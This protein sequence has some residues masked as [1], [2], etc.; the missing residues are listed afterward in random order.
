V[1]QALVGSLAK[2]QKFAIPL[3]RRRVIRIQSDG[4]ILIGGQF[5]RVNGVNGINRIARLNPNGSTDTTF[6]TGTGFDDSTRVIVVQPN[7]QILVGGDFT[8]FNGTTG[9]NGIARLNLLGSLD[10]SFRSGL[11][12]NSFVFA[13]GFQASGQIIR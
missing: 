13:I 1:R 2:S 3:P 4:R 12:S 10:T 9:V 11:A 6:N 7:G 5:T 8:S